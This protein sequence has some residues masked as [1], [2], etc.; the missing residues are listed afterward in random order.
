MQKS[1]SVRNESSERLFET[2]LSETIDEVLSALGDSTREAI[3]QLLQ[4]VY[5]I[6]KQ[7]IPNRIEGFANALEKTFGPVSKLI[8]I[9]IVE[10]M[11]AKNKNFCYAPK[12]GQLEFVE[13]IL[14]LQVQL[15][16]EA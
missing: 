5:G 16:P 15:D 11:H 13:F 12:N 14:S 3:Y 10:R 2:Q 9:K 7:D 8:E 4:K 1:F 6:S